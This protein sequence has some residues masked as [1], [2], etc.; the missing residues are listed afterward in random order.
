MN[1]RVRLVLNGF[2]QLS[3]AD[4][5]A[6]I[7]DLNGY[8]KANESLQKSIREDVAKGTRVTLGPVGTGCP[9]CGR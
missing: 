4:K 1:E 3:A 7:D 2:I 5:N 9:C 8:V 6:L